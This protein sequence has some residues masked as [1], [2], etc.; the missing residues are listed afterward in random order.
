M[1]G[2]RGA[3]GVLVRLIGGILLVGVLATGAYFGLMAMWDH[4]PEGAPR[5]TIREL[6]SPDGRWFASF[7]L[8]PN[9]ATMGPGY[10]LRL[11]DT[12]PRTGLGDRVWKSYDVEPIELKWRGSTQR[13]IVVRRPE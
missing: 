12:K 8:I 7:N 4:S 6:P 2:A 1:I 5:R 3:S 11:H 13:A 9:G 10:E